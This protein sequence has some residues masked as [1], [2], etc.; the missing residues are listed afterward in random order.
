MQRKWL[1]VG[2]AL[3][4]AG[5][6]LAFGYST[7]GVAVS[8]LGFCYTA[9]SNAFSN[10]FHTYQAELFPTSLRAT[11]AGSAHSLS[12]LATAAMPFVRCHHCDGHLDRRCRSPRTANHWANGRGDFHA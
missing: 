4:M 11:A 6:G 2:S 5:F 7:T 8:I 1:I 3:G 10:A 9:I 12:R